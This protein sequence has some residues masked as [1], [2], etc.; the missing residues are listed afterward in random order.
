[1]KRLLYCTLALLL[2]TAALAQAQQM[3]VTTDSDAA[4]AYFE[5]G[6]LAAAH[7]QFDK[8]R[9]HLDAALIADPGFALAHLYRASL[10][11]AERRMKHMQKAKAHL[12]DV[13]EG[14]RMMIESYEAAQNEDYDRELELLDA[15]AERYAD[16]PYPLLHMGW[17][18]Y[19]QERYAEAKSAADEAL[20]RDPAFGPAYNML[21]YIALNQE[22]YEAAEEALKS[23]VR[24]APKE[25]NPYDSLG[26]LYL[27]MGRYAE[28]A[29]QFEKALAHDSDFTASRNNLA[30]A[31]IE[32]VN[33]Q[34]EEAVA[35]KDAEALTALYTSNGTLLPPGSEP[36]SGRD[37]IR[38][39]WADVFASGVDGVDL[40]TREVQA[41]GDMAYELGTVSVRAGGAVVDEGKYAVIWQKGGSTWKLHRDI[42]NSSKAPPT[43]AAGGE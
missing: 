19:I 20:T 22:E 30:R 13:S 9:T 3:P 12:E 38:A 26:E 21:G 34:F 41:M 11:P 6:R 31:G 4:R 33:L 40:T 2:C 17:R 23:Y 25:A 1:M 7:V 28:A 24:L 10:S 37:A 18:Y 35:Q 29:A 42:W 32:Q 43:A 36:V 39:Y 15:A 14:E 5:Q 8:A 16:D 27:N